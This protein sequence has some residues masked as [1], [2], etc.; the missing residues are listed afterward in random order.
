MRRSSTRSIAAATARAS[1]TGASW[2]SSTASRSSTCPR[3]S[4]AEEP[5]AITRSPAPEV[6]PPE[7]VAG[8]G[9][10]HA[11]P[12]RRTC[13]PNGDASGRSSDRSSFARSRRSRTAS[14]MPGSA[15]S[16]GSVSWRAA[17][18]TRSCNRCLLAYVSDFHLLET[19]TLPHG[20]SHRAADVMMAS[21]D[22]AM[23]FH[24]PVA[25]RRLAAVCAREPEQLR[26]ARLR[27]RQCVRSQGSA[28]REHRAGRPDAFASAVTASDPRAR[29]AADAIASVT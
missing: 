11:L 2:R 29:S 18:T 3:R 13:R 16:S 27:V 19:A 7:T 8:P 26:C 25:W 17:R 10:D 21:I 6:T 15:T 24:R 5:A 14:R 9:R 22:H 4:S 12:A 20:L 1:A 28:R 23:W